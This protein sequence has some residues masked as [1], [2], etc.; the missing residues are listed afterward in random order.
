MLEKRGTQLKSN[1]NSCNLDIDYVSRFCNSNNICFPLCVSKSKGLNN[2]Y[3][4]RNKF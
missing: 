4:F 3:S 1:G 2:F